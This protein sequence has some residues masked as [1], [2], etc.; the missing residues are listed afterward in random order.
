[1]VHGTGQYW[2]VTRGPARKD[3]ALKVDQAKEGVLGWCAWGV[4]WFLIEVRG[5]RQASQLKTRGRS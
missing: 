2:G 3:N 1:M 5:E 4:C